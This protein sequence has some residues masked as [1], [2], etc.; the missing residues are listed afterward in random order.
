VGHGCHAGLHPANLRLGAHSGSGDSAQELRLPRTP[1]RCRRAYATMGRHSKLSDGLSRATSRCSKES[2][3]RVAVH[4]A[5]S[6]TRRRGVDAPRWRTDAHSLPRRGRVNSS[7]NDTAVG[8]GERWGAVASIIRLDRQNVYP[9]RTFIRTES[10]CGHM[11]SKLCTD[12]WDHLNFAPGA[13][14]CSLDNMLR[15]STR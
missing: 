14:R 5:G 1:P 15:A 3:T 7:R 13:T 10:G 6:D 12:S 9:D 4:H 11:P 2:R 8:G